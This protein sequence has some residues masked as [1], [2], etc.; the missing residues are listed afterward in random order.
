[1]GEVCQADR[2]LN[3][4]HANCDKLG[5]C[6]RAPPSN[7][8]ANLLD[9][10]LN[11]RS[12]EDRLQILFNSPTGRQIEHLSRKRT[13]RHSNVSVTQACYIKSTDREVDEAMEKPAAASAYLASLLPI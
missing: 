10:C 11:L 9:L 12:G 2:P 13:L 5:V 8:V 6:R 4:L 7:T 1:M 3:A